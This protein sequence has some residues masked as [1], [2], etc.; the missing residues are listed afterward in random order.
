[1][2]HFRAS[3]FRALIPDTEAKVECPEFVC[4]KCGKADQDPFTTFAENTGRLYYYC[5][6]VAAELDERE[7]KAT[8]EHQRN[9]EAWLR[10]VPGVKPDVT[11][12]V[13]L[14]KP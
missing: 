7:H 12:T 4:P 8:E 13:T 11:L 3:E 10:G 2:K 5:E 9:A 14:G 6:C 1:M